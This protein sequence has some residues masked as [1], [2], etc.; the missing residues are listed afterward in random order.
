MVGDEAVSAAN[1]TELLRGVFER[2]EIYSCKQWQDE[3]SVVTLAKGKHHVQYD[4]SLGPSSPLRPIGS[5][6]I[7]VFEVAPFTTKGRSAPPATPLV[8]P[9]HHP[10]LVPTYI[11]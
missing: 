7:C 5:A 10:L 11:H 9:L 3:R 2:R 1:E 6:V 4:S 8:S